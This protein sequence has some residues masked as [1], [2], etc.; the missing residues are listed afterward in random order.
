MLS[1]RL[2]TARGDGLRSSAGGFSSYR[3]PFF[4]MLIFDDEDHVETRENRG[5][6]IQV[7]VA[8]QIIPSSI[9]GVGCGENAASRVE[10][11][12]DTSLKETHFC[13]KERDHQRWIHL[14]D[15]DRLLLHRFV[16]GHTIILT[17]LVEFID[18]HDTAIGQ[19]H[20]TS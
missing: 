3:I 15:R 14:G 9:D 19:N 7:I 16:N 10:R 6:E 5:H 11:C 1:Q 12:G 20:R 8:F 17:H 4:V 2:D 13:L 18:A